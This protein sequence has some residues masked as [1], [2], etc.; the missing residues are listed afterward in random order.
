MSDVR[1]VRL[2]GPLGE[3]FGQAHRLAVQSVAEAV[4]ALDVVQPGFRQVLRDLDAEG[5]A[6]RVT[7]AGR[8]VAAEE[9]TLVSAGDILIM[10]M[11]A[12]SGSKLIGGA[13]L[14]V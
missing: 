14:V 4:V 5:L 9:I 11:I 13:M 1:T 10:P 2:G 3:R 8:D 6:F 12:G 7:V